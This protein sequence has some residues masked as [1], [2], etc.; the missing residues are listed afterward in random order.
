MSKGP[1][2]PVRHHVDGHEGHA[3]HPHEDRDRSGDHPRKPQGQANY[4]EGSKA[5]QGDSTSTSRERA[6]IHFLCPAESSESPQ[7]ETVSLN[8][9]RLVIIVAAQPHGDQH[10]GP[11]CDDRHV[12][13]TRHISER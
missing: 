10:G 13:K 3:G 9:A 12:N 11:E 5:Q 1:C 7:G 8:A 4:T 6:S 2:P